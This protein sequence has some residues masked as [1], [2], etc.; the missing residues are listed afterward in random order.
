MA[1]HAP[2]NSKGRSIERPFFRR[3]KP[4]KSAQS[5][6]RLLQASHS[7]LINPIRTISAWT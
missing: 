2:H 3:N 6:L 4:E 5:Q 1:N 7:S